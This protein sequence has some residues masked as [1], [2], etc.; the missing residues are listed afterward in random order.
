[1]ATAAE[2]KRQKKRKIENAYKVKLQRGKRLNMK[3]AE[4]CRVVSP[5]ASFSEIENGQTKITAQVILIADVGI[6]KIRSHYNALVFMREKGFFDSSGEEEVKQIL[7]RMDKERD[8]KLKTKRRQGIH[9][10]AVMKKKKSQK[11]IF[12]AFASSRCSPEATSSEA[13]DT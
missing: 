5:N 6:L 12:T 1:L 13:S 9:R 8:A 11:T 4:L 7:E 10:E 3:C 2:V